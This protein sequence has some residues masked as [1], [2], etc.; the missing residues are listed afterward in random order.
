MF[1]AGFLKFFDKFVDRLAIAY[2]QIKFVNGANYSAIKR[3][4]IVDLSMKPNSKAIWHVVSP[5][6]LSTRLEQSSGR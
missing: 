3:V 5:A 6:P 4:L 2:L 1:T